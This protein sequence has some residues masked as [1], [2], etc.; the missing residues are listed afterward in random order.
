MASWT[1]DSELDPVNP[2][3]PDLPRWRPDWRTVAVSVVLS[4]IATLA[5]LWAFVNVAFHP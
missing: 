1:S 2:F 4:V 5:V 3:A